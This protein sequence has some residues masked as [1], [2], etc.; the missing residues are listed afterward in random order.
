[1][2]E[3]FLDLETLD[4]KPTALI[5]SIGAVELDT[6]TL[7]RREFYHNIDI[8]QPISSSFSIDPATIRWW[9]GQSKAAQVALED[10]QVSLQEALF[11]FNT[12]LAAGSRVWGYG[13]IFDN[14]ILSNSYDVCKVKRPWSYQNDMCLR[15][16]AKLFPDI[17]YPI[18]NGVKHNALDDAKW[19]VEYYLKICN[20]KGL[21]GFPKLIAG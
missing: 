8:S 13:A 10:N 5:L 7:E 6:D 9:L 15:N 11:D 14:A 20:A 3:V 17:S 21:N 2:K 4:T 12:W 18:I 19:D 1:M 16:L